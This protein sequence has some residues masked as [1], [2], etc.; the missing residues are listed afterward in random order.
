MRQL[1]SWPA[2]IG[3]S[4]ILGAVVGGIGI[5]VFSFNYFLAS[6]SAHSTSA[7]ASLPIGIVLLFVFLI[8]A[9][10]WF[11]GLVVFG[12]LPWWILHR[13]GFRGL[14]HAV[15]LG[16]AVP[17]LAGVLLTGGQLSPFNFLFPGIGIFVALTIWYSTY[18]CGAG[19]PID[20]P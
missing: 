4:L 16:F 12:L 13:L 2:T 20:A 11:I 19:A 6:T 1:Q 18:K 15:I 17:F 5:V 10:A 3:R 14:R 9:Q 8:A 7:N